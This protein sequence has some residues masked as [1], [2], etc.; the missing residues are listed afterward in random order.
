[1]GGNHATFAAL[2][3]N[4]GARGYVDRA[5][6]W[7]PAWA[8]TKDTWEHLHPAFYGIMGEFL[9]GEKTHA[10]SIDPRNGQVWGSNGIRTAYVTVYG[11]D[12]SNP[13]WWMGPIL[14][15][16]TGA[17]SPVSGWSGARSR[18]SRAIR[19]MRPSGSGSPPAASSG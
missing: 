14:F 13:Q 18:P 10:L 17:T 19:P 3:A 4:P 9:V 15:D 6:A 7:G 16:P 8:D 2:L 1:M 5:S 11:P 12:L